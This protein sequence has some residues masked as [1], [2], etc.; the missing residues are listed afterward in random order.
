M[1]TKEPDGQVAGAVIQALHRLAWRHGADDPGLKA[2]VNALGHAATDH[3]ETQVRVQAIGLLGSLGERGQE[4]TEALRRL[5]DDRDSQ[6][7]EAASKAR[8]QVGDTLRQGYSQAR[9]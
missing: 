6:V 7:R 9:S 8:N 2:I 1:L 5:S 3:P 4:A